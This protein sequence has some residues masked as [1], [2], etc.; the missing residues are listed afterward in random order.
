MNAH[1]A[2]AAQE[3]TSILNDVNSNFMQITQMA[4]KALSNS[5]DMAELSTEL[6]NQANQ[7]EKIISSFK[8]S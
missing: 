2:S 8:V 5:Q 3:Q 6:T 7:L 4:E 1:I